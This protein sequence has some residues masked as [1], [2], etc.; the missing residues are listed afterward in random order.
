MSLESD[1]HLPFPAEEEEVIDENATSEAAAA[2]AKLPNNDPQ[3]VPRS[4]S[5]AYHLPDLVEVD[6]SDDKDSDDEGDDE[7]D[8][9]DNSNAITGVPTNTTS[10]TRN[11]PRPVSS[12]RPSE[13][14]PPRNMSPAL[15]SNRPSANTPPR[16]ALIKAPPA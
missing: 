9:D 14:T 1:Y 3:D 16:N 4:T 6:S 2:N 11:I 15:A 10:T 8:D 13:N 12:N 7:G 5:S